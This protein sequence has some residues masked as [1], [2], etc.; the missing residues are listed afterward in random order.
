[1]VP[2]N[3]TSSP[4]LPHD[5]TAIVP[6]YNAGDRLRPVAE[7]ILARLSRLIIV[8][9]GCTDHSIDSLRDLPVDIL[10]LTPN[11]GKGHALLAGLRRGLEDPDCAALC[12]LDADGQHNPAEIPRL[13]DAF[14]DSGA[15]LVIGARVFNGGHIP[16]R[17][18]F[19]NKIT[20]LATALLLRHRLP[21]TQCGFRLLSRSF[22]ERVVAAIEGG[23]YET[24]MAIIA[25][26]IR[27]RREIVS[28]PISTIYEEGNVCSH[29]RK[30][31]DSYRIYA[32]L[33]RAGWAAWLRPAKM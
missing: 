15:D 20:I 4:V 5:L 18:R 31:Q 10:A 22:A 24:E 1:M 2:E 21:D 23:R 16:W 8:D 11:R 26:A 32:R 17:S 12:L 19:G 29:F 14:R 9:D 3:P 6:C 30:F 13:Y 27:E 28:V 7:G 33:F 25:L